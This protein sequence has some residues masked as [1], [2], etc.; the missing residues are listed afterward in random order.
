MG[1]VFRVSSANIRSGVFDQWHM[2]MI[3]DQ[4]RNT[5]FLE[6]LKNTISPTDHVLD[7][8]TGTGIL[9]VFAARFAMQHFL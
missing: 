5:K 1:A 6:A 4:E 3:N 7:I 2:F 8:G 9:S